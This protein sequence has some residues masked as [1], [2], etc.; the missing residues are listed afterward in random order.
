MN[1]TAFLPALLDSL[2]EPLLVADPGHKVV[3]MNRAAVAYYKG[4]ESLL[5]TSLLDCHS[6]ASQE[7]MRGILAALQAGEEERLFTDTEAKRV[8]MRAVRG[9]DGQLLGYYERYAPPAR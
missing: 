5:G 6:A 7:I 3:Y 9:Q 2:T 4:G 8:Y 1:E